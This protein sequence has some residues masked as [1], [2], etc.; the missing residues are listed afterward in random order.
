M[1]VPEGSEWNYL[2][3]GGLFVKKYQGTWKRL[4]PPSWKNKPGSDT[5]VFVRGFPDAKEISIK[6]DVV[7]KYCLPG[8]HKNFG[9]VKLDSNTAL[10]SAHMQSGNGDEKEDKRYN[11]LLCARNIVSNY[12]FQKN[13]FHQLIFAGDMNTDLIAE[14]GAVIGRKGWSSRLP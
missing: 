9:L 14:A 5:I 7:D 1:V 6:E 13:D 2:D 3:E 12:D 8:A 10:L 4:A 11:Q